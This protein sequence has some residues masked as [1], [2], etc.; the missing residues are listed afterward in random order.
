[1]LHGQGTGLSASVPR[2]E[3]KL[4]QDVSPLALIGLK[5][6]GRLDFEAPSTDY[7]PKPASL[8]VGVYVCGVEEE[9]IGTSWF[10]YQKLRS[11][12]ISELGLNWN[13]TPICKKGRRHIYL[14]VFGRLHL[15]L[16]LSYDQH[17]RRREGSNIFLW[18]QLC[19]L[20]LWPFWRF[21]T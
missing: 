8:A 6:S 14:A 10:R 3:L 18:Q 7:R 1:M 2:W 9:V 5:D 20:Y 11:L 21:H 15:C 13:C 12:V 4:G 17:T 19:R 16:K